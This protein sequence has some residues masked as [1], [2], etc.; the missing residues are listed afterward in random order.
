LVHELGRKGP[1]TTKELLDIA[2]SFASGKEAVGTI[3]DRSKGKAKRDEEVDEG[4]SNRSKKK[5]KGK[6]RRETFL[7]AVA[8]RK[9]GTPLKKRDIY[10][11]A[12]RSFYIY[13]QMQHVYKITNLLDRAAHARPL[14]F[15]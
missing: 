1:R 12:C 7:V 2:T 10:I 5:N 6:Q 13:M 3:F 4:P 9:G 11:Y 15:F 8:D 14:G